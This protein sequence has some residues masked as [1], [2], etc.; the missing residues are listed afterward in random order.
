MIELLFNQIIVEDL[1]T[2]C[3]QYTEE[4]FILA[5]EKNYSIFISTSFR[6]LFKE[7]I[8]NVI[9][10]VF[11]A[12]EAS[13]NMIYGPSI[14]SFFLI[15]INFSLFIIWVHSKKFTLSTFVIVTFVLKHKVFQC[16]GLFLF[17]IFV[18]SRDHEAKAE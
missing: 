4:I 3:F 14:H 17:L 5:G 1:S 6:G 12:I 7:D 13:C 8:E 16:K 2:R 9:A 11:N 18:L 10:V 15:K